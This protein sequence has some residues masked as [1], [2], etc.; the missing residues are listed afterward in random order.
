M[1]ETPVEV[2]IRARNE[3]Q[4]ALNQAIG[5]L[6]ALEVQT[7][8]AGASGVKLRDLGG[9]LSAVSPQAGAAV[10]QVQALASAFTS[11]GPG[12][13]IAAGA[14]AAVGLITVAGLAA[15]KSLADTVEQLDNVARV[16]GAS[17]GDLQVLQ[18]LFERQGIGAEVARTALHR[19]NIAIAEGNPALKALGVSSKEPIEALFQLADVLG[20]SNDA[21]GKAKVAQELLGRGGKDLLAAVVGLRQGFASLDRE[22]TATGQKLSPELQG[23]ARA[24]D[25]AFEHFGGRVQ[26]LS[27]QL[28]GFAA[29]V[30][31]IT[32]LR[33]DAALGES[34]RSAGEARVA[35]RGLTLGAHEYESAQDSANRM[36]R[37]A[38][39]ANKKAKTEVSEHAR[40]VKELVA[41][42]GMESAAAERVVAAQEALAKAR[43]KAALQKELFDPKQIEGI[44]VKAKR[45]EEA[46]GLPPIL[47]P[48]ARDQILAN[49]RQFVVEVTSS[50]QVLDDTLHSLSSGLSSG[51]TTVFQGLLGSAQTFRSAMVAIF[52]A[53]VNELLAQL[54]RLLA[55]KIIGFL[56]GGLPIGPSE[57]FRDPGFAPLPGLRGATAVP[58]GAA[59]ALGAVQRAGDT[60]VINAINAH[61]VVAS[62]TLP[63]GGMRRAQD[64]VATAGAY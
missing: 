35:W 8:A 50:A 20:M 39:E 13:A 30:L 27:N 41:L 46:P 64:R 37:E 52:T 48:G 57:A 44:E 7:K 34:S 33:L 10:G 28:K 36:I 12:A 5:Q 9:A 53:M 24:A 15:A 2:V 49:W 40:S 62:L 17:V 4:A 21:A 51:L 18:E 14:A 29:G 43:R 3:A 45:T 47:Q 25:V 1:A 63:G 60:Y 42:F 22:M 54:A 11:L 58:G 56:I 31:E 38:A 26:G 23:R 61:D 16:T 32:L 19:L 55:F 6:K 59:G